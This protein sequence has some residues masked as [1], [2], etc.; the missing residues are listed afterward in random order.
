[1]ARDLVLARIVM[2]MR[3]LTASAV[4][5][6]LLVPRG[7]GRSLCK[8]KLAATALEP[9]CPAIDPPLPRFDP[10]AARLVRYALV[11]ANHRLSGLA[12]YYSTSL[13]GTLPATGAIFRNR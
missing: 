9:S 1:M 8:D 7:Q 11:E 12:S 10:D 6:F 3:I 4:V 5:L 2:L 13:D